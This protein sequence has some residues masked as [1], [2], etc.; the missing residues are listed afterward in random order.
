MKKFTEVLL[1][2]FSKEQINILQ[3]SCVGIIG[4]GG[5][6]SNCAT[7]LVRSGI[8]KMIIADFD[9]INISNLNR[10]NYIPKDIG[11][12]KV[13][14]LKRNLL[15][16]NRSLDIK[17]AKLKITEENFAE[18]FKGCDIIIE[19]VDI[20]KTKQMIFEACI[21]NKIFVISASGMAG[22]GGKPMFAK[23]IGKY[24]VIVGDHENEISSD[25]SPLAPRVMLA[26]AMQADQALVYLLGA[27][28]A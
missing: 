3:N 14:I 9:K 15:K 21:K 24:G 6:G 20:A 23:K 28:N 7:M 17:T 4:A 10:Q 26:A 2:H 18:L 8:G 27:S 25:K 12:T 1:K 16:I 19:A 11:K 5:L 13:K 22:I